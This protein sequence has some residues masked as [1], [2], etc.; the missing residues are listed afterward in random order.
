MRR[1]PR[2]IR[3]RHRRPLV[4][5]AADADEEASLARRLP[6]V[7][8]RQPVVRRRRAAAV[9]PHPRVAAAKVAAASP[10]RVCRF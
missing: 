9:V 6:E 10:F 7:V 2:A 4:V 1:E 8:R 3:T 5:D